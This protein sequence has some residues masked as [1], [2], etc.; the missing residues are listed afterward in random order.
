MNSYMKAKKEKA[1]AIRQT[2]KETAKIY[3]ISDS[4][5]NAIESYEKH[6][7]IDTSNANIVCEIAIP[8][9][10]KTWF[11]HGH[12]ISFIPNK[13]RKTNGKTRLLSN[14]ENEID[15]ACREIKSAY[16]RKLVF[17]W[18]IKG[19]NEE[20]ITREDVVRAYF[21]GENPVLTLS[22]LYTEYKGKRFG[23]KDGETK[24]IKTIEIDENFTF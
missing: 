11:S 22:F 2:A 4:I 5:S 8:N 16:N 19:E 15:T 21:K 23:Y 18:N 17:S 14:L 24:E 1:I 13:F 12:V 6:H 3:E 9:L 7:N 10:I 20:K